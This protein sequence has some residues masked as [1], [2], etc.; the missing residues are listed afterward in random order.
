MHRIWNFVTDYSLLLVAA[1]G[2]ALIWANVA[3]ESYHHLV[4]LVL[5]SD[6]P[7]GTL[8]DDN[9]R[10]IRELTLHFLV[11]DVLMALFFAMAAKEVWEAIVL[12][13]GA[14]RGKKAITPLIATFGGMAGPV[15]VYLGIAASLGL[16]AEI[17]RGWAI[18]T[19]TDIAFSYVVGRIVF[20][21]RHPAIGFLLLLAIADDAAGLVILA[22]FYPSGELAPSWLLLSFGAAFAAWALASWLPR[23]LDRGDQARPHSSFVR[24][25]FGPWPYIIAGVVSWYGFHRAGLH[26]ALGL[27]PVI[28]AIPHAARD[29]GIFA[30]EEAHST[31][32]LN[33][34]EHALKLP[35]QLILFGFGLLNA[36]VELSAVSA[37][38][39]AVL[40]GLMIGKPI[41]ITFFGWLAAK[42]LGLGLPQGM[43][44][45]D[46]PLVGFIAAIGFTV[47]LFVAS[48][49]FSAG[50]LQD[51]A[52]MGALLSLGSGIVTIVLGRMFA[53]E[54]QN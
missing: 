22:L 54:R 2:L 16:L 42:P 44:M 24:R 20:G 10:Q 9:G 11:N 46:L 37:T 3:P 49:A 4:H 8:S 27:L 35:V 19:A 41:G 18:P 15:L 43:V 36:G 30:A 14:L 1:A 33:S 31:D 32:L 6:A 17:G 12:E 7:I 40:A 47:S 13:D 48:V 38:T 21:A 25:R 45:R 51:A 28:P 52:K 34:M 53:V 5:W 29:F 26:P 39:F 23:R 50:G